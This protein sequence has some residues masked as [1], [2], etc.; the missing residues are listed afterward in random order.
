MD[1]DERF[2]QALHG[3][4]RAWRGAL[5]RRLRACGLTAAGWSAMAALIAS[6]APPSQRE[7]ARRLGVDGATL[8]ATIDRLASASLVER[9]PSPHDRRVKLVVATEKGKALAA[10]IEGFTAALRREVMA[11]I[12]SE[13]V[14]VAAGVLEE[15]RAILEQERP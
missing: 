7:L 10:E 5:E 11:H 12:D 6:A 14:D 9:M 2:T 1:L 4:A 8:V 3:G 13:R 15:L